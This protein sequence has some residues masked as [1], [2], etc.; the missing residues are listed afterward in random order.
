VDNAL[1]AVVGAWIA[2]RQGVVAVTSDHGELLGEHQMLQHRFV[3]VP[4]LHH[5]P[6]V[7]VGARAIPLDEDARAAAGDEATRAKLQALGYID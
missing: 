4:E 6:L 2:G 7:L 3:T 1:K 5:V